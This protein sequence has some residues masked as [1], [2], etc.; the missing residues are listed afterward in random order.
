[1]VFGHFGPQNKT[2]P[3]RSNNYSITPYE[4]GPIFEAWE[5]L[6]APA[7]EAMEPWL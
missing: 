5:K 6:R 3:A 7:M 2:F 1:M 4:E